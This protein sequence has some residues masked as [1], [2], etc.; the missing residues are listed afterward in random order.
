MTLHHLYHGSKTN[1]GE[2]VYTNTMFIQIK[3]IPYILLK[4]INSK[5]SYV[6]DYSSIESFCNHF[7]GL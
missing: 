7:D 1:S 4:K 6:C 2:N 3:S 5:K